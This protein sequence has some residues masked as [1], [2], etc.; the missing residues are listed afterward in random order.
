MNNAGENNASNDDDVY[1]AFE[2]PDTSGNGN[3]WGGGLFGTN[4]VNPFAAMTNKPMSQLG[5]VPMAVG[6]NATMS[7]NGNP[8]AQQSPNSQ[9][10]SGAGIK[11]GSSWG[12]SVSRS[13]QGPMSATSN[14]ALMA[15]RPMT[16]NK[17]VGF[18]ATGTLFDPTGQA[19]MTNM[20]IGPAPPLKT[21]GE[22]S[23]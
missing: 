15:A 16:S 14:N 5:Q 22:N 21:R 3:P 17:A 2:M 6:G 20:A 8:F 11:V 12:Y 9:W 4:V 13:G 7:R 18:S 19:R 10:G 23:P 1:A